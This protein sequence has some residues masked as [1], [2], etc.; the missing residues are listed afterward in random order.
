MFSICVPVVMLI[1]DAYA[2]GSIS[3]LEEEGRGPLHSSKKY[4]SDGKANAVYM[5]RRSHT[6]GMLEAAKPLCLSWQYHFFI[7]KQ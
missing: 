3:G 1:I 6:P 7:W 5:L 2:V 4:V